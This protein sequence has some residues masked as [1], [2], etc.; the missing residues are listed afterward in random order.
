[1]RLAQRLFACLLVALVVVE[2]SGLA[3]AFGP[4]ATVHCCCGAHSSARPCP[5]PDCPVSL[6]RAPAHVDETRVATAPDCHGH[7]AGDPGVLTVL[8]IV[9]A[10]LALPIPTPLLAR[11]FATPST[12]PSRTV[13]VARPPP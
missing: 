7:H 8:A 6:H 9:A 5:C 10:P 11:V 13:D 3:R 1:V 4:G 2:T 12:P